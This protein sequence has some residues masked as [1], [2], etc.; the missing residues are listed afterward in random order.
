MEIL[1]VYT[2]IGLG[3]IVL[4][5]IFYFFSVRSRRSYACPQCG[6]RITTEYLDARRCGMCGAELRRES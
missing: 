3:L 2:L 5:V 6:E 1:L 4:C